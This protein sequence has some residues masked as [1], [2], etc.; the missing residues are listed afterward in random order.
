VELPVD[1]ASHSQPL[2]A[3]HCASMEKWLN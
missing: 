1:L 3:Y 2:Y